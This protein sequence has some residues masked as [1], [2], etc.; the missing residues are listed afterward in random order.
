MVSNPVCLRVKGPFACFTRPEFKVER[1]TY[2]V[3]TPSAARGIF[4]AI[5]MK[6]VEKPDPARRHNKVGFR[7]QIT[8][9]GVVSKGTMFSF[10]RNELG[11]ERDTHP[12]NGCNISDSDNRAQ[13]NSLILHE[14]EYLLEARIEV[15]NQISRWRGRHRFD[16]RGTLELLAKYHR[17]F[18]RRALGGQC[19]YQPFLGCREFSVSEWECLTKDEKGAYT[20]DAPTSEKMARMAGEDFGTIFRDFDYA[21][22]WGHWPAEAGR[23]FAARPTDWPEKTRLRALPGLRAKCDEAGWIQVPAASDDRKSLDA[24]VSS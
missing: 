3:I 4:E 18:L 15:A 5:L 20:L 16:F 14:V 8:K 7:W 17:S 1:V 11:Y 10:V 9:I 22:L 12:W 23:N 19:A 2:P 6:P 24:P 21:H 13:R